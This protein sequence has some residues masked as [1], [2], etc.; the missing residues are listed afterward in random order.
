M[1][2]KQIALDFIQEAINEAAVINETFLDHVSRQRRDLKCIY[3]MVCNVI[4][5][6]LKTMELL[7]TSRQSKD[8]IIYIINRTRMHKKKLL[9]VYADDP[10]MIL[11]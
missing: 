7:F 9:N 11:Y 1:L 3:G 2:L 6:G 8:K 10:D 5:C 4:N